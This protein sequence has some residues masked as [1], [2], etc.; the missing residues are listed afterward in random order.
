[1]LFMVK[2]I[3]VIVL[4]VLLITAGFAAWKIFGASVSVPESKYIYIK[5]G[6]SYADMRKELL[7]KKVIS[8]TGWFDLVAKRVNYESV[9]PGRYEIKHGMSLYRLVR[10]LQYGRQTPVN[11]VIVKFRTKEDFARRIGTYL[12]CDSATAMSFLQN[13]DSLKNYGIDSNSW[14][15]KV[16]P[17]TYSLYWNTSPSKIF[18]KIF[19]AADD[20]WTAE[21]KQKA[22]ALGI[23]T[24]EVITIASIVEEETNAAADKPLI[25]SVY[26]NRVQKGMPLQA[27]PTVKFAMKDFGLK[28]IYQ[29]HLTY[30][31]PFNTY[32]HT[33]LPPGPIC[34]P[35]VQTIDA[36]LSSPQTD[37]IYFVANS[38]LK[39]G[40]VFTSNYQD[41]LKYA[42][43]YQQ[44]LDSL[45]KKR[46]QKD[47]L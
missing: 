5:T 42:K 1:M 6:S 24:A 32:I 18:K 43:L 3:I 40:S 10:M 27:D 38:D 26:L 29:K 31:S 7:D 37:Y 2:R 17:N 19:S 8:S 41:H 12:E 25:T 33:G 30:P 39:G 34:T 4:L 9:K 22:A 46:Q 28:R 14:Y 23:S 13:A 16:I 47:S 15:T 45:F 35:S 36:V 44:A 20:F 21:R 11:F